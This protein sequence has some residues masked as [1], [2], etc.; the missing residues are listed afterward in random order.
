MSLSTLLPYRGCRH[1][2][3][4]YHQSSTNE[5]DPGTNQAISPARWC[6]WAVLTDPVNVVAVSRRLSSCHYTLYCHQCSTSGAGPR[7]VCRRPTMLLAQQVPVRWSADLTSVAASQRLSFSV[8]DLYRNRF[9]GVY[10][11]DRP[12]NPAKP[13]TYPCEVLTQLPTQPSL[14]VPVW[15]V[16]PTYQPSPART[17]VER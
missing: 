4:T 10:D 5:A 14:H 17:R 13:S 7:R 6:P 11:E 3:T 1:V 9:P 2:T 12:T 8:A 16:V 15:S